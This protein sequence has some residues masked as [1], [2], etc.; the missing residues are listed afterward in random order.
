MASPAALQSDHR[1]IARPVSQ[2]GTTAQPRL[3]PLHPGCEVKQYK[4][5]LQPWGRAPL[6]WLVS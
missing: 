3:V 4:C 2:A 6:F 5:C 1:G